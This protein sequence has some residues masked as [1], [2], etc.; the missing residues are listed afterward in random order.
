MKILVTGA[1]GY[2]GSILVPRLLHE[3]YEVLAIDNFMYRQTTLLDCCADK[4]FSMVRGDVRDCDLLKRYV[5]KVDAFIP[6]ACLTARLCAV[7]TPWG[8]R[9]SSWTPCRRS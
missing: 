8:P 7:A 5:P 4:R 2:I 1:A 9:P 6:L 3:G